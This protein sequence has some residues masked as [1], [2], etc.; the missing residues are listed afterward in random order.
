M[1]NADSCIIANAVAA[2]EAIRHNEDSTVRV[3][4]LS[5]LSPVKAA[6]A[7]PSRFL[8]PTSKLVS[9]LVCSKCDTFLPSS[10]VT[11]FCTRCQQA[12]GAPVVFALAEGLEFSPQLKE[13]YPLVSPSSKQLLLAGYRFSSE[14]RA[15]QEQSQ[16]LPDFPDYPLTE[17][18]EITRAS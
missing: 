10:A 13:T 15:E 8:T 12:F 7:S 2:L 16:L 14:V 6:V 9:L 17:P 5:Y 18:S 11:R 3:L 4:D 1:A